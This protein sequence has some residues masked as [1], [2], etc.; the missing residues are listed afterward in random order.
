MGVS[1]PR[2]TK[3]A[4][5]AMKNKV[6][7]GLIRQ[8]RQAYGRRERLIRGRALQAANIELQTA[9]AMLG[10]ANLCEAPKVDRHGLVELTAAQAKLLSPAEGDSDA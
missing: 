3:G 8:G 9:L 4:K 1:I 10:M 6:L 7:Q 5:K 2:P